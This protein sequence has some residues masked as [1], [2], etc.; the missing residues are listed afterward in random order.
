[1]SFDSK[2][3]EDFLT[4]NETRNF[5]KAAQ[6]RHI[7]QPAFGRYIKALEAAVGQQLVDRSSQPIRFTPAGKQFR[8]LAQSLLK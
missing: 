2:W 1:M 4:L 6:L 8:S 3:L 7:T 5:S